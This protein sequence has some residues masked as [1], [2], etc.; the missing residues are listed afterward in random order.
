M[1]TVEVTPLG[2]FEFHWGVAEPELVAEQGQ[3]GSLD[4]LMQVPHPPKVLKVRDPVYGEEK[5]LHVYR[6][7]SGHK[8]VLMGELSAGIRAVG[9][10]MDEPRR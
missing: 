10:Q 2:R 5:T 1:K 7:E 8:L 3:Q 9:L 4:R 6:R